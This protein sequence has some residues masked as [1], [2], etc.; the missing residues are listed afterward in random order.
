MPSSTP[1][2]PRMRAICRCKTAPGISA[3]TDLLRSTVWNAS[4]MRARFLEKIFPRPLSQSLKP[5][6][7]GWRPQPRAQSSSPQRRKKWVSA[8]IKNRAAKFGGLWS[9][10]S[11]R[12][13]KTAKAPRTGS[14][15]KSKSACRCQP[16][17][18]SLQFHDCSP[19]YSPRSNL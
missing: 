6:R 17:H 4:D 11:R 1:Q 13:S 12:N 9:P 5:S 10:A 18:K 8:G 2:P 14:R 3:L 19:Q 16:S 15:G 7:P